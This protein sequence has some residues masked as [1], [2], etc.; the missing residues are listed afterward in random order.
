MPSS[1]PLSLAAGT[2][3][4]HYEIVALLGAGGMGE[5]YRARDTKL[6]RDVALKVLPPD[7]AADPERRQRFE[8]E[9]RAVAALN[10]PNIVT[11]YSVD[12]VDGRLFLTMELVDGQPLCELIRPGGLPLDRLLEIATP[13]ADAVSAA[14]ARGITH[15]DLKP[16]NVMV[17][18]T[19]QVKVLDF[20]LAKLLDASVVTDTMATEAPQ[21]IT[22]QGK[23]LGTIAYMAPEQAEG[24]PVDARSDIFSLGVMLYEMATG[25]RPFKGD[26]SVSTLAAIMRDTPKSV[27]EVNPAIPKEL[28]RVIRRA[29]SKDP[30][31]RQQ[32]GKDLRNDLDDI[33]KDL[34]SGE[35]SASTSQTAAVRAAAPAPRRMPWATV[36]AGLA[37]VTA[38][39]AGV[40]WSRREPASV[41][42]N[43]SDAPVSVTVT[44]LTSEDGVE[45]FPSLSPDGKWLVY[46]RDELG[47]G[48]TDIL[49]R[50]VGGQTAINLT[51]DSAADDLQAVLSPDGERIA[52]RSERDGGGLFV[53]G[54]TG[55]S[56]RRLTTEG[57][58]PSWSPDGASIVYAIESVSANP[59]NRSARSR[60]WVSSTATGERRQLTKADAVQPAWSPHGQ[61]IAYWGLPNDSSQRDLWTIAAGGGE[62]VRVTS[63]PA[64]DW[65][66]AWSPDGRHLYFSSDRS[67]GLNLWRVAIDEATGRLLGAPVAV[68]IPRPRIGQLSVSA[69]GAS[70]AMASST[71]V[72]GIEALSFDPA[73]GTVGTRRRVTNSS[74]SAQLPSVSPDGRWIAFNTALQNGQED[75]WVVNRDGTGLRQLTNDAARDRRPLWSA[76]GTRLLFYSDRSGRYQ[77]WTIAADGSALM[78][79]TDHPELMIQPVW[80]P[81]GT[82]AIA[83]ITMSDNKLLMFDPRLPA[84]QQQMEELPPFAG[85][86]SATSWSADGTR[87][88]GYRNSVSGGGVV[89]YTV[90]S[91][92]YEELTQSGLS[93]A[94]LP[95]GRRLLYTG[96]YGSTSVGGRELLLLDTA[97]KISKPVYSSPGD[98]FGGAGLSPDAREIFVP[99]YRPQADIVLARLPASA[100]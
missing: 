74:E 12:D 50:A 85:G 59:Y 96:K 97:T 38:A 70:I 43:T 81:D 3:L 98:L 19:R 49:L 86:F 24:K 68:P 90:A 60:L 8:R 100:P 47:T 76:D 78:Q 22:G 66:P 92:A 14:H 80:S 46:T 9:A 13:L 64:T 51:K 11:I 54:R 10:H 41:T 40:V 57:F 52:F 58:N 65:S 37:L 84:S 62:P 34:E 36:A 94:W 2:R 75:L 27:T 82:R 69:D 71:T 83:S 48:Q 67:G 73:R 99:T 45:M 17:T 23:I 35:L 55:E 89:I 25:E 20:G 18:P 32:T 6:Q 33:R 87:V 29:L 39:G 61:R 28:G 44:S 42:P 77:V 26:T 56:V 7:T 91:R 1:G 5:V 15:R 63:D 30:D 53:M 93:P 95:D 88:A 72:S 31:R 79:V 4:A 16:A 21:V